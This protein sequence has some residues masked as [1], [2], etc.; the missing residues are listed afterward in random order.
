[1]LSLLSPSHSTCALIILNSRIERSILFKTLIVVLASASI[2]SFTPIA[3][4]LVPNVVVIE[5]A[6]PPGL[7]DSGSQPE[8]MK[9]EKKYANRTDSEAMMAKSQETMMV[10]QKYKINPVSG[11]LVALLQIPLFFAFLSAINDVP[12][13][14]EDSL[15]G[16]HLGMTP[17]KALSEGQYAY[18][19][20]I[21]LI[22]RILLVC[23]LILRL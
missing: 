5:P 4:S 14:F 20:L 22:M 9:I 7:N 8:I 12:A 11:C 17:W 6:L 21:F 13:I 16:M 19:I 15:F 18:I 10:Y 23:L 2:A 1:M 3:L